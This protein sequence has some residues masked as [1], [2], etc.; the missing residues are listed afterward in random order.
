MTD[1][2][3]LRRIRIRIIVYTILAVFIANIIGAVF[4]TNIGLF[5]L[6]DNF[7]GIDIYLNIPPFIFA[8]AIFI[9]YFIPLFRSSATADTFRITL[10]KLP[11]FY[12]LITVISWGIALIL[13][14]GLP[15]L[16]L[17]K[18]TFE[19]NSLTVMGTI[20]IGI[21]S[22]IVGYYLLEYLN[23]WY[24]IPRL[25][26]NRLESYRG[27]FQPSI[28]KRFA[29]YFLGVSLAPII[30]GV[31]IIGW[32]A[33]KHDIFSPQQLIYL[34]SF[35]VFLIITSV[36]ATVIFSITFRHPLEDAT[37]AVQKI[38]SG[39]FSVNLIVR[40]N[41]ELGILS[42]GINN[43]ASSLKADTEHIAAL[44]SE[45]ELTQKEVIFTMGTIGESRSRETGNHVKRVAEYSKKLALYYGLDEQQAELLKQASPMHDIG[46]VGIPDSILN[47]P[48]KFTPDEFEIMKQHA[49]LGYNL[50]CHSER[51]LLKAA[52]IVAFEHHEKFNGSGYPRG[53]V[54]SS[55]HIF[56]RI[57]ALADVFDALGSD[58][59]YKKAWSDEDIFT[60]LREQSN[61]HFDP[62]LVGI[63]FN[64]LPDFLS[65]RESLKDSFNC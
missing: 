45:I 59:M 8:I 60:F 58:R 17:P 51:E 10:L 24:W 5:L 32:A 50:L 25:F 52:S 12:L 44:N 42:E 13:T 20:G 26:E 47:K 30:V 15:I 40:S 57:T 62:V 63:F 14:A 29:V 53:L 1:R 16:Y 35:A 9:I 22:A 41:D 4:A 33:F 18:E 27:L 61:I 48:G 3:T 43:M 54:G 64:N 55:I 23:R 46:K 37:I 19:N 65:I 36:I 2:K 28:G 21:S 49:Q 39:D 11:L 31:W 6:F 56:G 34:A 38:T 7:N